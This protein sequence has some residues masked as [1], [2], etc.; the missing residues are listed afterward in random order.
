MK[1]TGFPIV[2]WSVLAAGILSSS[3]CFGDSN[4]W[5]AIKPED[6][7]KVKA[8]MTLS[9][10][11]AVLGPGHPASREQCKSLDALYEQIPQQFRNT[12]P[13]DSTDLAWGKSDAWVAARIA[14]ADKKAWLVSAQTGGGG[15][16]PAPPPSHPEAPKFYFRDM[17][18]PG[19]Q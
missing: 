9:E 15:S 13:A 11:E 17:G 6:T 19:P 7:G 1:R 3:G 8:G 14:V 16:P 18:K 2:A 12:A 10:I 4:A 5:P